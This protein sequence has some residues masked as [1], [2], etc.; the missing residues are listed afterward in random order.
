MINYYEILGV[1]TSAGSLE[2]KN[3]FRRLAKMYH[4]DKNPNGKE[5][6][7]R[8]LKAYEILSDPVQKSTYDYRLRSFASGSQNSEPQNTGTK[9]WRFDER[10]LKRRQYYN[11]YI[12]KQTKE[13][14]GFEETATQKRTYS[15]YKYIFFATPLAVLLFLMIMNLATPYKT[16]RRDPSKT[17]GPAEQVPALK[18]GSEAFNHFFSEQYY[19]TLKGMQLSFINKTQADLVITLSSGGKFLRSGFIKN[20]TTL[21]LADLPGS[22]FNVEYCT[23]SNFDNIQKI[24]NN[25]TARAFDACF[26]FYRS[27]KSIKPKTVTEVVL[28]ADH[29]DFR[30]ITMEE[31]FDK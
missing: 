8:I 10:E 18:T 6:F 4:P 11:E 15:D 13:A 22:A 24:K 12:K 20:Y 1:R 30:E 3:A 16:M 5:Q 31:F 14:E 21:N 7:N 17:V 2:I 23:G 25:D 19:D 29:R 27:I 9:N 26:H 28:Q